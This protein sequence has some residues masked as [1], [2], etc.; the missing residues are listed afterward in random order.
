[1]A[2]FAPKGNNKGV[3]QKPKHLGKSLKKLLF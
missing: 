3:A 2:K 1:M